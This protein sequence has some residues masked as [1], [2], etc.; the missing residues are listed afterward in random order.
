MNILQTYKFFQEIKNATAV[1]SF[2]VG[3]IHEKYTLETQ[4]YKFSVQASYPHYHMEKPT[5]YD[6]TAYNKSTGR[7][8]HRDG[9]LAKFIFAQMSQKAKQK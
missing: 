4:N 7:E 6:F 1:L 9:M 3:T 2:E 5:Q 8:M